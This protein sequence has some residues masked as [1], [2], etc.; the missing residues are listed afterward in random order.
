[1]RLARYDDG[2]GAPIVLIHSGVADSRMWE[3]QLPALVAAGFRVVRLDLP[4]FGASPVPT[5]PY[6]RAG[7]VLDAL[8]E[9]GAGPAVVVGASFGGL[10]AQLVAA[11]APERVAALMLVCAAFTDRADEPALDE[12]D[13]REEELIAEGDLEGAARL[14]AD[15]WLGPDAGAD[16][17]AALLEQLRTALSA[18]AAAGSAA[19]SPPIPDVD[20]AALRMP[21]LVLTG[22]HDYPTITAAGRDHAVRMPAARYLH[23]PWAGHLPSLE[24]PDDFTALLLA[25]AAGTGRT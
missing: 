13:H 1:M 16:A 15:A 14:N 20:P 11:A 25:F 8:T 21:A 5:E 19:V 24:R 17:R 18:Q 7:V 6:D 22:G 3:P 4:G 9:L 2:A 23:L 10:V 12:L